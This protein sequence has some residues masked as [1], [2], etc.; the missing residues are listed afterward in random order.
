MPGGGR[1]WSINAD[2]TISV[3]SRPDLF[4]GI[5]HEGDWCHPNMGSLETGRAEQEPSESEGSLEQ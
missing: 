4:L 2:G 3:Q 1:S 5:K